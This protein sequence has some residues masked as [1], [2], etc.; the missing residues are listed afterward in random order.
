MFLFSTD[1]VSCFGAKLIEIR[2]AVEPIRNRATRA[3]GGG[4]RQGN[5]SLTAV[6]RYVVVAD[7]IR[8]TKKE[9]TVVKRQ[10][11][12]PSPYQ[13]ATINPPGTSDRKVDEKQ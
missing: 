10:Y 2:V 1:C 13:I 4:K 6:L 8:L 11:L 5:T 9:G 3:F 12:D 7:S